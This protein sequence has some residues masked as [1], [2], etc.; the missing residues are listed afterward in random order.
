MKLATFIFFCSILSLSF[1]FRLTRVKDKRITVQEGQDVELSCTVSDYYKF[2]TFQHYAEKCDFEY[3]RRFWDMEESDCSDFKDRYEFTGQYNFHNCAIKI[4]K[5]TQK[6]AGK[7]FCDFESYEFYG[8]RRGMGSEAR[9]EINVE[10]IPSEFY[11]SRQDFSEPP[12][13]FNFDLPPKQYNFETKTYQS[14]PANDFYFDQSE[15]AKDFDLSNGVLLKV[16]KSNFNTFI[17]DCSS[18][19][20]NQRLQKCGLKN[21]EDQRSCTYERKGSRLAP[22][23]CSD[24]L[25]RVTFHGSESNCIFML[26]DVTMDDTGKWSCWIGQQNSPQIQVNLY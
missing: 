20:Q 23:D 25:G 6:D 19:N 8:G 9:G 16:T 15:A 7:W 4:K 22:T 2:C 24:F 18:S 13:N 21:E 5:V 26:S 17:M 11:S 10:V 3:S 1:G 14:Q 12:R